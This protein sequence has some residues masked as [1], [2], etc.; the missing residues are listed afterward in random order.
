MTMH[1][2]YGLRSF[3]RFPHN[4][5]RVRSVAHGMIRFTPPSGLSTSN[6][7]LTALRP[8]HNPHLPTISAP[9]EELIAAVGFESRHACSR[10]HLNQLRD[11]ARSWIDSPQI[12]IVTFPRAVPKFSIDPGEPPLRSGWFLSC[13]EPPLFRDRLDGSSGHD[14]ALPRVCLRPTRGPS[15]RRR[16]AQESSHRDSC[17]DQL[18]S[19]PGSGRKDGRVKFA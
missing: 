11:L 6:Q 19:S 12:A 18:V 9:A 16:S 13:E 14:T 1:L 3:D 17:N 8:P 7:P 10:R 2:G 5:T 15:D 4:E